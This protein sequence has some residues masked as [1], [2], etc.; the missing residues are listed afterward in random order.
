MKSILKLFKI[1]MSFLIISFT[2]FITS[3]YA[4]DEVVETDD[5]EFYIGDY[6]FEDCEEESYGCE[7]EN[8][9]T[10]LY[11]TITLA[12]D[13]TYTVT[14]TITGVLSG[15]TLTL[16]GTGD[17]PDYSKSTDVPWGGNTSIKKLVVNSGITSIGKYNFVNLTSL[18]SVSLP[19]SITS[20]KLSLI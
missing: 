2:I 1:I 16:T 13:I 19:S 11:S 5:G 20:I 10:F 8:D 18:T 17:M 4:Y 9:D 7:L 6:Y 3:S 14:D 12:S 15:D